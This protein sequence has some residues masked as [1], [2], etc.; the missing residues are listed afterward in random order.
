MA[1]RLV[2]GTAGATPALFVDSPNMD[3][4]IITCLEFA[5]EPVRELCF[6]RKTMVVRQGLGSGLTRGTDGRFWAV[7][8]RGPNLKLK[9]AIE[10]YGLD[11]LREGASKSAKMMP[12][13]E[14]GPSMAELRVDEGQLED[15][16]V[17]DGRVEI[18]RLIPLV[19]DDGKPLSG[20]PTPGSA[21][22]LREP[23]LDSDG[24]LHAP[25]PGGVDSEGIAAAPDGSFWIGDEYGPSLL[26]VDGAGRVLC[27]W[28]PAGEEATVAG[29]PYPCAALLPAIAA[30]RQVNRGF[31]ALAISPDGSR[32]HLAFQSPLAHPDV[33]AHE[34]ARHVRLWTLDAAD[35]SL[36]A[37][38]AYP[39]DPPETFRRDRAEG[40]VERSDVKVGE[41]AAIGAD[42]L[43]ILERVSATTKIY[44]V[45]LGPDRRLGEEQIRIET[46][47][48]LE[49]RSAGEEFG[50]PVLDKRLL[51]DSD[52]HPEVGRDLEGMAMIDD[53]TLLLVNDNDFGIEDVRTRFWKVAFSEP[54]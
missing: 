22:G 33:A 9:L 16:W 12:A 53:R 28:V 6:P 1:P 19:G 11:A 32:L 38:Y 42:R 30:L 14:V 45:T 29:A 31:E 41:M 26:R 21:N 27:R 35:G 43:L 24:R 2:D 49:Q 13:L 37:Q 48:T 5:D 15:G 36:I 4:P 17:E 34:A 8:D 7:G 51:F 47:P 18:V 39:L 23:A 20:L 40:R 50:L 54:F 10:T 46:R 52:D 44:A 3:L 25:D